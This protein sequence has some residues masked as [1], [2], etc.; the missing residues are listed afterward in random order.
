MLPVIDPELAKI[1]SAPH[2]IKYPPDAPTSIILATTGIFFW[3][4]LS[5]S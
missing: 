1:V 2:A 5:D 3:I 4:F